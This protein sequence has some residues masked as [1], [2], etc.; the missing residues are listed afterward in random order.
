MNTEFEVKFRAIDR[1]KLIT[2]LQELGAVQTKPDT[3][4]RRC[5]FENARDPKNSYLRVRDESGTITCT[6]KCVASG[7]LSI[8][9][10]KELECKVSDFD[11]MVAIIREMGTRQKSYQ[12]TRREVWEM[13][14]R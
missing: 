1:M 7:D 12:E 6:Y 8:S 4:M 5:I 13:E 3:L 14:V 11:T 9:S 10:V 2:K